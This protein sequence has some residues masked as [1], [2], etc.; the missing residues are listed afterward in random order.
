MHLVIEK[1]RNEQSITQPP[2]P[3]LVPFLRNS[4]ECVV[5]AIMEF[6]SYNFIMDSPP[7]YRDSEGDMILLETR[8]AF[9]VLYKRLCYIMRTRLELQEN[10]IYISRNFLPL[11]D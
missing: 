9:E 10:A 3:I 2:D 6:I 7:K 8:E 4:R 5:S 11:V 1:Y